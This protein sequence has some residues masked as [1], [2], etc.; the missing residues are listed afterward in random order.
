M[1]C[2]TWTLACV[3]SVSA[4]VCRERWDESRF[5]L[6]LSISCFGLFLAVRLPLWGILSWNMYS[7]PIMVKITVG[8]WKEKNE[9]SNMS[10]V[11]ICSLAYEGKF[12]ELKE[13][14]DLKPS[15]ATKLD[16]VRLWW[17]LGLVCLD[18]RM[19]FTCYLRRGM[20]N[21]TFIP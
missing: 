2:T 10:R 4:R 5:T 12:K 9:S 13:K 19:K 7:G 3:A 11:E 21:I 6:V 17:K 16:E 8:H 15:L 20:S 14:I 18:V 1:I